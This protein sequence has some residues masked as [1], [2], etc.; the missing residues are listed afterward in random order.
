MASTVSESSVDS[1]LKG[2]RSLVETS[3]VGKEE[4][5]EN[6]HVDVLMG[7]MK[8]EIPSKEV[9]PKEVKE[10]MVTLKKESIDDVHTEKYSDQEPRDANGGGGEAGGLT[11]AEGKIEQERE[12]N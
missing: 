7:V 4:E 12:V 1:F 6:K 5:V 11:G 3:K 9:V 8:K 2:V 10:D